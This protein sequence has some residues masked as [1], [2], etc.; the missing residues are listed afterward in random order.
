[1]KKLLLIIALTLGLQAGQYDRMIEVC[2]AG[3]S[4]TCLHLGVL[5]QLGKDVNQSYDKANIFYSKACDLNHPEGCISLGDLY[6]FGQGVEQNNTKAKL[7]YDKS[8]KLNNQNGCSNLKSLVE[9]ENALKQIKD[10]QERL[11]QEMMQL[12]QEAE[13]LDNL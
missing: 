10:E 3:N 2:N 13:V 7:Y 9:E 4:D 6:Y 11:K 1:M 12:I 5:Y 8:C